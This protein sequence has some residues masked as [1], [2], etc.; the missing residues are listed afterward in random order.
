MK[1]LR[2]ILEVKAVRIPDD[3]LS[4]IYKLRG[5][6]KYSKSKIGH[7]MGYHY[8]TI[9]KYADSE[10]NK[11]REDYKP[12]PFTTTGGRPGIESHEAWKVYAMRSKGHSDKSI[13]KFHKTTH[14]NIR[15]I[16]DPSH[17]GYVPSVY[18]Q[19]VALGDQFRKDVVKDH[20]THGHSYTDIARMRGIKRGKVA[21][22][23]DRWKKKYGRKSPE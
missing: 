4:L 10:E 20:L 17:E 8:D 19:R 5:E 1:S 22:I 23:V 14:E 11:K 21:G 3:E 13:A 15:K 6:R 7:I 12:H 16:T 18:P 2:L 9:D